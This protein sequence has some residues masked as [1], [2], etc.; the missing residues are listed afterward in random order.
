MLFD[1]WS[2]SL[3]NTVLPMSSQHSATQITHLLQP[4]A[5][6]WPTHFGKTC[7]L[8]ML[9]NSCCR[10]K[11]LG[12]VRQTHPA[13]S[14]SKVSKCLLHCKTLHMSISEPCQT[15]RHSDWWI[16]KFHL[17]TY[18]LCRALVV[19][20]TLPILH[21]DLMSTTGSNSISHLY[22]GPGF[23]KLHKLVFFVQAQRF[24]VISWVII[25]WVPVHLISSSIPVG[26]MVKVS[27]EQQHIA[28]ITSVFLPN[29]QEKARFVVAPELISKDFH[30]NLQ[31][32]HRVWKH[33]W[34]GSGTRITAGS[35]VPNLWSTKNDRPRIR[36]DNL[37]AVTFKTARSNDVFILKQSASANDLT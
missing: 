17:V 2:E 26:V 22:E 7:A 25:W 32:L 30:R 28:P 11:E 15:Q 10:H 29:F 31:L 8:Y 4:L 9:S 18:F 19:D 1:S 3:V 37:D 16:R 34:S 12:T 14:K 13:T 33:W 35:L 36:L 20:D 21:I 24:W 6:H 23:C 5:L 27:P